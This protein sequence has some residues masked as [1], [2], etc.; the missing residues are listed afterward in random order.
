M[1][2]P[3]AA[4]DIPG[5]TELIVDGETGLLAPFGDTQALKNCWERI[6]FDD[7]LARTLAKNGQ[8]YV[9]RSF[10]AKRMAEEYTQLY[11]EMVS[12]ETPRTTHR[13]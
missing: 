11:R 2:V 9:E 12:T 10:S 6:L 3:V 13:I 5:V 1:G 4:F 7:E 8:A